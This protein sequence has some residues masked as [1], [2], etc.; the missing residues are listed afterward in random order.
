MLMNDEPKQTSFD[1]EDSSWLKELAGAAVPS[2]PVAPTS[3]LEREPQEATARQPQPELA[4]VERSRPVRPPFVPSWVWVAL[5][6]SV[7][8]LA[9]VLAA[10]ATF[11]AMARVAVPDVT[12]TTVGVA[13][14]RLAQVGLKARVAERRFSTLPPDQVIEQ[15]PA[16]GTQA[17]RGDAVALV[18]SGGSEEFVMPDVIGNGLPLAK[19][20]LEDRGLVVIVEFVISQ[21]ASDT[22]LSSTPA[23]GATVRTGDTVR[24][25]VATSQA[26]GV[27]LQPYSLNGVGVIIDPDNPI[28]GAPDIS[29]EV[30][31]RL[32]SLLEASGASVTL[33]RTTART[34]EADSARAAKAA[35]SNGVVAIGF[36]VK[37]NG[38]A[39]RVVAF[40][41]TAAVSV[42]AT[43]GALADQNVTELSRTAPPAV[44]TSVGGDNVFDAVQVPW[45]RIQLGVASQRADQAAFADPQWADGVA[46]SVYT[47][48]GKL[49]G[50]VKTP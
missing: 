39:G 4:P 2:A 19:G 14:A 44:S 10:V 25:Q 48:L 42:A 8:V 22:I 32:G 15:T 1:E 17:Q 45:N 11:T 30:A 50:Q 27:E 6:S 29:L 28:A 34:T 21:D 35:G 18:V 41:P 13:R 9:I 46:R 16:P 20:T 23:A 40:S 37:A 49:Y 33:L 31:R 7:V 38:Q 24:L 5:G 47:A 43:S 3:D 36:T 26:P 12:G